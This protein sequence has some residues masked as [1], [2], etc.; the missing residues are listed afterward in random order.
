[1]EVSSG[2]Y[3]TYDLPDHVPSALAISFDLANGPEVMSFP[4]CAHEELRKRGRAFYSK[5]YGG[6]WIFTRYEDIRAIFQNHSAFIQGGEIPALPFGKKFKPLMV[7]PPEHMK[8]RKLL[9]PLFSPIRLRE[10]EPII[11]KIVRERIAQFASKGCTEFAGEF[12]LAVSSAMF[13]GL[14]DLPLE[15]FPFFHSMSHGLTYG[16]NQVMVESGLEAAKSYRLKKAS[17][18]QGFLKSIMFERKRKTGEDALSVLFKSR[19][20]GE[21]LSDEE[22]VDIGTLL[23]FAGTDSTAGSISYAHLYL[24]NNP[25]IRDQLIA[26]IEDKSYVWNAAEELIRFNGFHHIA[27]KAAYD[28]EIAG[29]KVKQGESVILPLAAANHDAEMFSDPLRVDLER[30]N[31]NRNL[32]FGA[33]IHR[34]IG[35]ALATTQLRIALEEIHQAIPDY[36][37]TDRVEF[38]SAGP[39]VVPFKL[40]FAF[41]PVIFNP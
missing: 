25:H 18:I 33:G 8:F 21:L 37:L 2:T 27:R 16:T 29:I 26:N 7:D 23:F 35:S 32:T 39:K 1:M 9:A 36:R 41:S 40:P 15:D 31:A 4:P 19:V 13:C 30:Q 6:F 28:V 34:C 5:D 38:S 20:D 10:M 22:W 11:R 12:S 3:P 17:E 14:L 24:A